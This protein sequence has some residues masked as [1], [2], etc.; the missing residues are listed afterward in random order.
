[1]TS[2]YCTACTLP[3]APE[4]QADSC[5]CS[6]MFLNICANGVSSAFVTNPSEVY[7]NPLAV[8]SFCLLPSVHLALY[9]EGTAKADVLVECDGKNRT[10]DVFVNV[11]LFSPIQCFSN[12]IKI[13]HNLYNRLP[14]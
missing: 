7:W 8:V 9:L 12:I 11:Y 2:C 1:M 3:I 6:A 5:N 13:K 4:A 10:R 14:V